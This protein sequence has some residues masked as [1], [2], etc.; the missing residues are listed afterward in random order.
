MSRTHKTNVIMEIPCRT[1][2][3]SLRRNVGRC[4]MLQHGAGN[5]VYYFCDYTCLKKYVDWV[6]ESVFKKQEKSLK[7]R[8]KT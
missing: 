7:R 8:L 5:R 4:I 2:E 6:Y 3:V 1:C